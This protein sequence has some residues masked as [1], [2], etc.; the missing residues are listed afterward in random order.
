MVDGLTDGMKRDIESILNVK[1]APCKCR[2]PV[3]PIFR[4]PPKRSVPKGMSLKRAFV[5]QNRVNEKLR[6]ICRKYAMAI[7]ATNE[8]YHPKK[9]K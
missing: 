2:Y 5:E 9:E 8:R 3:L 1:A 4:V 6:R 7:R